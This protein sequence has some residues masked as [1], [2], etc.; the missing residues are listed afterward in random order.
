M[1]FVCCSQ[2][3]H[4]EK[5]MCPLN[6]SLIAIINETLKNDCDYNRVIVIG[7]NNNC[8]DTLRHMQNA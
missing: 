2:Y 7:L 4:F 3:V 5:G 6:I 1:G 8:T